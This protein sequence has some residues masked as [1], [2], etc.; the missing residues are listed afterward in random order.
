MKADA[1]SLGNF[2]RL[3]TNVRFIIP[4]YQ[5]NYDWKEKQCRT[6]FEDIENIHIKQQKKHFIGSIVYIANSET[7]VI[8][9][10]EYVVIDGQQRLTT[11]MLFL[12][13]LHDS[14]DNRNIREEIQEDFLINKR[15]ENNKLKLKPIKKDDEVFTK[16]LND[17]FENINEQSRI[18][19]NYINFKKWIKD[20]SLSTDELFI[21]F[22][23]LW[24]VHI[25]LTRG[26]DDPQLIF[27]SINSTGLG[28]KEADLI[29]N[30]ILM[31][32]APKLQEELFENYWIHIE[33]NLAGISEN[34][35]S[36]F[37]HY[38]VMKLNN[39]VK[40]SDVYS[41][42]KDFVFQESKTIETSDDKM[43]IILQDILYFSKIYSLFLFPTKIDDD[44]IKSA[45]NDIKRLKMTVIYPYLLDVYNL[46]EKDDISND[47]L[48]NVLETLESYAVRRLIT[49]KRTSGLNKVFM[50]LSKEIKSLDGFSYENYFDYFSYVLINKKGSS[51]FP[52][53]AEFKQVFTNRNIYDL[54]MNKY[55]L[56]KLEDYN[57]KE[58]VSEDSIIS[59][60]HIMPKTLTPDWQKELGDNYQLVH[61]KYLNTIGNLT[62][63]GYNSEMGNKP[64][65]TKKS[66]L[67]ESKLKL[68]KYIVG[69]EGWT[70]KIIET[71]AVKLFEEDAKQIWKYP[72]VSLNLKE[73]LWETYSIED[74]IVATNKRLTN[75]S[76]YES[77]EVS[78]WREFIESFLL[79]IY[80]NDDEKFMSLILKDVD[81]KI[82]K[83][84]SLDK[85][86]FREPK[87]IVENIYIEQHGSANQMLRSVKYVY[88]YLNYGNDE[89]END[90]ELVYSLKK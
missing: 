52:E 46:Y 78:S 75:F 41:E 82:T 11:S 70:Q 17:N 73:T 77:E 65:A 8:G 7:N 50:S 67:K 29:R 56:Q 51:I 10:N 28:L 79:Q 6:L 32:K 69:Q 76:F 4:V 30:F 60:E 3:D 26:D 88:D 90:F 37:H 74:N 16:L 35:S 71:R 14:I 87:N 5:R 66:R 12:K 43:E 53:D 48:T 22:K 42:F 33:D 39:T 45:M 47:T 55:I 58:K 64:F 84:I 44:S 40:L 34:I 49:D 21:S 57:N 80:V 9:V 36:F 31:D 23:K 81:T 59:I 63:T 18:Y 61:D 72:I 25:G 38:L 27:E 86:N 54:R 2:F 83:I 68:N 62:L 1:V 20:S 85:S 24:I 89:Y 19:T 15:Q 13:A